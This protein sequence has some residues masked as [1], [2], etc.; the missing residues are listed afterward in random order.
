MHASPRARAFSVLEV[1]VVIALALAMAVAVTPRFASAGDQALR[2][3]MQQQVIALNQ[4]VAAYRR[5]NAGVAPRLGGEGA[6]GWATLIRGGYIANAPVNAYLGTTT[7]VATRAAPE[8]LE[9]DDLPA[10]AEVG[11]FY[12]PLS[13][14]IIANGFDHERMLFHD[15]P[16]Y[17][18]ARLG[19]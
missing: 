2:E 7:I 5:D 8:L 15:E 13:G 10:G 1:L 6:E 3:S 14:R 12:H 4:A 17:D 9:P 19:W 16:G 11:W 18:S